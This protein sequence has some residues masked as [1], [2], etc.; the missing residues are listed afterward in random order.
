MGSSDGG[1]TQTCTP[2]YSLSYT[3]AH[4]YFT[5]TPHTD[6]VHFFS[7]DWVQLLA[8]SSSQ[9][10]CHSFR[11]NVNSRTCLQASIPDRRLSFSVVASL[12][13]SLLIQ[14]HGYTFSF[15]LDPS[16]SYCFALFRDTK[17][18]PPLFTS[19]ALFFT[20][21]P[22]NTSTFFNAKLPKE[23]ALWSGTAR[24]GNL[25]GWVRIVKK[26]T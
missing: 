8:Y 11:T 9:L 10:C 17:Q 24:I 25:W 20:S 7:F 4:S 26:I 6:R 19:S 22:P 16:S 21:P 2:L 18:T 5:G 23:M 14:T 3:L 1:P 15:T 13:E 12:L